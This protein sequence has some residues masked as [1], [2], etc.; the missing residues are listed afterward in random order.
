MNELTSQHGGE[1]IF[2]PLPMERYFRRDTE[3]GALEKRFCSITVMDIVRFMATVM[4]YLW[5]QVSR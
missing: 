4:K 5:S 3:P 1:P 2:M